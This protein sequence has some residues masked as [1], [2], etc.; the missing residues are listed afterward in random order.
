MGTAWLH[1]CKVALHEGAMLMAGEAAKVEG[2][3]L[4]R[5]RTF[6][7]Y[8]GMERGG[9]RV[10]YFIP[11]G[12][13]TDSVSGMSESVPLLLC[14]RIIVSGIAATIQRL[15]VTVNGTYGVGSDEPV[16]LFFFCL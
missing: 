3:M 6:A 9:T 1:L 14:L 8:P 11:S 16:E 5:L 12:R 4:K 2:E 10:I 15:L 7:M 13:S